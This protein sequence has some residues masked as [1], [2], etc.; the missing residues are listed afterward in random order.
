M[1]RTFLA[2]LWLTLAA[3][4]LAAGTGVTV[5]GGNLDQ[6]LIA[7]FIVAGQSNAWG[8]AGSAATPGTRL[9]VNGYRTFNSEILT[10]TQTKWRDIDDS[11]SGV[12]ASNADKATQ[13]PYF[14][15]AWMD[16]V[17]RPV[18]LIFA[19]LGGTALCSYDS[20]GD[21]GQPCAI[22]PNG[23]LCVEPYWDPD[24]AWG[25]NTGSRYDGMV[26]LVTST[27]NVAPTLRAV[28]WDQGEVETQ[29]DTLP[30]VGGKGAEYQT[31]L[32][33]L[34]DN[35]WQDLKVPMIIAPLSLKTNAAGCAAPSAD[36]IAIHDAQDAA[37]AA[38]SHILNT[39]V[40]KDDLLI[41]DDNCPHIHDVETL[42]ERWFD[43]V[44]A[45]GL[46]Y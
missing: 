21:P 23:A 6:G 11:L 44:Q 40:N 27:A 26:T 8:S 17:G 10:Y 5:T 14:A 32:E 45:E 34:A 1:V 33:N 24:K 41:Q 12:W 46:A 35:I 29:Y 30:G 25:T 38:H 22:D 2:A 19:P 39:T 7:T 43:A 37:A 20:L 15:K 36:Y 16:A 4:S 31:C 13:W 28:L 9:T 18:R 42:G 3:P